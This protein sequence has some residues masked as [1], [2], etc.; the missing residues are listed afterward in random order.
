MIEKGVRNKMKDEIKDFCKWFLGAHKRVLVGSCEW[1]FDYSRE[2]VH[3]FFLILSYIALVGGFVAVIIYPFQHS[4]PHSTWLYILKWWQWLIVFLSGY[5]G[6]AIQT[7]R[8][9]AKDN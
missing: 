2:T 3:I 7:Y 5:I 9:R 6:I 1:I 8:G 4:D